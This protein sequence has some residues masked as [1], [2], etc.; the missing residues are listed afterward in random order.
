MYIKLEKSWYRALETEFD[1][2]YFIKLVSNVKREYSGCIPIYPKGNC[3]FRALDMLPIDKV[4]VVILGQDPYHGANQAEGLAFSVPKGIPTPPS[5]VNI[6][7]EIESDIGRPSIIEEGSLIPWVNQGVLLLNTTLT[8]RSGQAGSH[9]DIG[10]ETFTDAIIRV[11]NKDREN[12]VFML[13]GSHARRKGAM[14]DRYKHCVLEAPHPSPLSAYRGFFG[15][16]HFSR[17]NTY[18][19]SQDDLPI[20]W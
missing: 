7:E 5:L 17:A 15:C 10:W 19:V 11:L 6:K 8:V 4:R 1:K 18:L 9:S 3:I 13:W 20:K 12:L 16:K 14:I 2:P